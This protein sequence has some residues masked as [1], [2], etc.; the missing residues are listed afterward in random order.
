MCISSCWTSTGL[1]LGPGFSSLD[2]IHMAGA[3]LLICY[4]LDTIKSHKLFLLS[5]VYRRC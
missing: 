4:Q 5:F 1:S 3:Y 2:H